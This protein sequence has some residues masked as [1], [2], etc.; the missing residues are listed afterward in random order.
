MNVV[1]ISMRRLLYLTDSA[2]LYIQAIHIGAPH[3]VQLN[4]LHVWIPTSGI[5]RFTSLF[6]TVADSR[7]FNEICD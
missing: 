3:Y 6:K 4:L 2:P 5:D 1:N 7:S